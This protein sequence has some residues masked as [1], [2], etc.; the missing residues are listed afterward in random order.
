MPLARRLALDVD[1][2]GAVG[3]RIEGDD[4]FARQLHRQHRLAAG[5]QVDRVYGEFGETVAQCVGQIDARAP[6]YLPVI[7]DFGER[8]GVVGADMAHPRA[9]GESHLDHLVES[10][11]IAGSA[12]TAIILVAIDGFER[13]AGIEHAAA[14]GTNHVPGQFEETEPGRV[15]KRS[16]HPLLVEPVLRREGERIDAAEIAVR[17]VAD[18]GLDGRNAVGVGRLPQRTEKRF[19]FAHRLKSRW[20]RRV[21]DKPKHRVAPRQGASP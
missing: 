11:L 20:C 2:L 13:R 16:D 7:F 1:E 3:H 9:D 21:C 8:V 14:A 10:G 15:Q 12:E 5:R 4:E 19:K 18:R 6:E 17:R